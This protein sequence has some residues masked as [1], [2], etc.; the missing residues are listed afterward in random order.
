MAKKAVKRKAV[1]KKTDDQ[2]LKYIKLAI[3]T[4]KR[5]IKFYTEAKKRVDDYNM[6]Q[7]MNVLL[8]QERIHLKL[9]RAIYAAEKKGTSEAA[10][11]AAAY[12]RQAKIKNPLFSMKK[13]GD[14]V[15]KKSSIYNLFKRAVRF[16]EDGHALYMDIAKKV[17]NPKIKS[18]LRMVA[19]EELRHREFIIMHQDSVYNTGHWY[20]WEHVRLEM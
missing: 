19:K 2:V 11:V 1:P 9:F 20:G 3:D 5:G 17:R 13:L 6:T 4:E 18:F 15:R 7:L 12:K 16:E 10:K 14:V 8:E